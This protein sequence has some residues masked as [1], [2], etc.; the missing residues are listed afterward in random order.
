MKQNKNVRFILFIFLASNFISS[1]KG[2]AQLV[3]EENYN[4]ESKLQECNI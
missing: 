4:S 1:S 2:D 3:N